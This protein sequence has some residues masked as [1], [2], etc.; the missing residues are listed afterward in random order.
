MYIGRD[1]HGNASISRRGKLA[2][3][4]VKSAHVNYYQNEQEQLACIIEVLGLPD[5]YLVD[6]S[7]RRKLFFGKLTISSSK[8]H[9]IPG[10][11]STGAPRPVVNSKGRRRKPASKTL[12]QVIKS[13]DEQFLDF[14][15]KCLI[16][17]PDRR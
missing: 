8:G 15:S 11:D 3:R 1:V 5:K 10:V 2:G 13:D 16:Y 12:A 4:R 17:D 14:I 7:S 6:R 9:L